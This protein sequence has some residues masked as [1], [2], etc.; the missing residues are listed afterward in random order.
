MFGH[1]TGKYV[2]E[3]ARGYNKIDPLAEFYRSVCNHVPV[4]GEIIR[5]LRGKAAN[6]Y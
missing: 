2:A 5:G 3:V 4:R 6:V 1:V